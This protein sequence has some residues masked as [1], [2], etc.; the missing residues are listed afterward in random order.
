[1]AFVVLPVPI[2][3]R[4]ANLGDLLSARSEKNPVRQ[5][6][7]S[8]SASSTDSTAGRSTFPDPATSVVLSDR[9]TKLYKP[10]SCSANLALALLR[11]SAIVHD[12]RSLTMEISASSQNLTQ[13]AS[14]RSSSDGA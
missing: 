12:P 11:A 10:V 2:V 9:D 13:S 14:V 7:S 1:M 6:F 4:T 5:S 3:I 8:A